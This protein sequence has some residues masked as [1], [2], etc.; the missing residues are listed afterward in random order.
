M[1]KVFVLI[2]SMLVA[3][4]AQARNASEQLDR[5]INGVRTM[6]ANFTQTMK[7]QDNVTGELSGKMAMVKPGLFYWEV[8]APYSQQII[9]DGKDL[10]VY[11]KDLKQATVSSMENGLSGTPALFLSGYDPL[12]IQR[13]RI[14]KIDMP[15][16]IDGYQMHSIYR[17][18]DIS[19]MYLGF[20]ND[21]LIQLYIQ[22][23]L[24][25]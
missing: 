23:K 5:L 4:V 20:R 18:A 11:D 21:R 2:I 25:K 3:T 10:W 6:E 8:K 19:Y 24:G 14:N 7:Q 1:K 15:N 16:N 22:D 9:A 12:I 13:Y 17:S